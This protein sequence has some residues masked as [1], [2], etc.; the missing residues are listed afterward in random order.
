MRKK[1]NQIRRLNMWGLWLRVWMPSLY[2]MWH[3]SI[4]FRWKRN[5]GPQS[6]HRGFKWKTDLT[7]FSCKTHHSLPTEMGGSL[8]AGR[9]PCIHHLIPLIFGMKFHCHQFRTKSVTH[10][11][12][13]LWS[14][15]G[16]DVTPRKREQRPT[17]H[18][19]AQAHGIPGMQ[20]LPYARVLVS[21]SWFQGQQEATA[22][23]LT[24]VRKPI[25]CLVF[26]APRLLTSCGAL[27]RGNYIGEFPVHWQC[28]T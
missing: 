12:S 11:S 23:L 2:A 21:L 17:R 6:G 24:A 1:H 4:V 3:T 15:L 19:K 26:R 22:Q 5:A 16:S 7:A 9:M 20:R 18:G 14:L 8:Y 27:T 28:A 13:S 10:P 25:C